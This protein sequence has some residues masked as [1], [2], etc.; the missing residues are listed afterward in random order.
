M[1]TAPAS[2]R[3]DSGPSINSQNHAKSIIIISCGSKASCFPNDATPKNL[4]SYIN[5]QTRTRDAVRLFEKS[6]KKAAYLPTSARRQFIP[7]KSKRQVNVA[8]NQPK[9]IVLT[10]A[11]RGLGLAMV[12]KFIE[13]GHTVLGCGRSRDAIETLRARF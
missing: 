12:E 11:T 7:P 8:R 13:L 9:V 2:F 10:G 4:L 5:N 6:R 3:G 1:P